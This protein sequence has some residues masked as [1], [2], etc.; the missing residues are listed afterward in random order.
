MKPTED[1]IYP[2]TIVPTR[3]TGAYEGGTWAA[4]ELL[5]EQLDALDW[6]SDD[7]PAREWWDQY[8]GRVGIGN[9]PQEAYESLRGLPPHER[10]SSLE[11][12]RSSGDAQ[13][14]PAPARL[15]FV[16]LATRDFDRMAGFYRQFRWPESKDSNDEFVAFQTGGAILGLFPAKYYASLGDAPAPGSFK[17]FELAMNLEDAERVDAVYDAVKTFDGIRVLGGPKDL[18]IGGRSFS[19]LDPEGNAWEVIWKSG[20]SFDERGGLIFP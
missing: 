19:F 7:V 14:M 18:S 20:T 3:Y 10:L 11:T 16:T 1:G 5:P 6:D 15:S 9:S 4:F 8:R 2:C 13:A 12:A 17:G